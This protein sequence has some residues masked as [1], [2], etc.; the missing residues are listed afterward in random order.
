MWNNYVAHKLFQSYLNGRVQ[1]VKIDN[2][3]SNE[4]DI[5]YSELQGTVLFTLLF[6]V[7]INGLLYQKNPGK[8]ICFADDTVIL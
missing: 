2:D 3:Y 5:D 6:I 1:R 7:Y 8:I 4:L